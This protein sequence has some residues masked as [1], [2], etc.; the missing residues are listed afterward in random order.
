MQMAQEAGEK[1]YLGNEYKP[2]F[3]F[4]GFFTL[5]DII[6]MNKARRKTIPLL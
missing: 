4:Y 5:S 6:P 2:F 3:W 1:L